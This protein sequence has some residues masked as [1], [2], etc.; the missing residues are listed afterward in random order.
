MNQF[1]DLSLLAYLS[2]R[3]RI[4]TTQPVEKTFILED[5]REIFTRDAILSAPGWNLLG[6][7]Y[8]KKSLNRAAYFCYLMAVLMRPTS[9][10]YWSD[11][12]DA[13]R[14]AGNLVAAKALFKFAS[15]RLPSTSHYV[16]SSLAQMYDLQLSDEKIGNLLY[17]KL[18]AAGAP[19]KSYS[20]NLAINLKGQ[21]DP[22]REGAYYAALHA[23]SQEPGDPKRRALVEELARASKR[24]GL[25]FNGWNES[26]ANDLSSAMQKGIFPRK[27]TEREEKEIAALMQDYPTLDGVGNEIRLLPS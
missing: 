19:G 7:T 23:Y 26:L 20:F 5:E 15:M 18:I 27:L 12:G 4:V 24:T 11:L 13:Y 21:E 9:G 8:A 10:E 6:D 16:I 3:D 17:R 2:R 14:R 22:D 25:E 1:C